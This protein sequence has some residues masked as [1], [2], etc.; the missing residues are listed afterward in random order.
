MREATKLHNRDTTSSYDEF[1]RY[2]QPYKLIPTTSTTHP[3]NNET[4]IYIAKERGCRNLFTKEDRQPRNDFRCSSS[5]VTNQ[6]GAYTTSPS[7]KT[8]STIIEVRIDKSLQFQVNWL[9]ISR[10]TSIKARPKKS[11]KTLNF[12]SFQTLTPI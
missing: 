3:V 2:A 7:P 8:T 1:L 5:Q 6:Y 9:N 11:S 4:Y 12:H 10:D